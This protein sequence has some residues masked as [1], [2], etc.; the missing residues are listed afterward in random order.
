MVSLFM[1]KSTLY[2]SLSFL[3][4]LA[5]CNKYLDKEPDNRAQ[6][7]DTKKVSEILG[8][9]YPLGNYMGFNEAMSD[10]A[11][12][13]GEGGTHPTNHD[14]YYF[15]NVQNI[16]EDSPDFY[17]SACYS[18]I[19]AAN[20]ALEAC[21]KA[22]NPNDY[23]KQKGEALLAR[24]Y[25]HF[26]LV[27]LYAKPYDA[28]TS[29]SDPGIPYV[30]EP[31]TVVI[32]QYDRKTV[33]YVY[34]MIEKDLVAGLPLIDDAA[35]TVVRY[36][37]NRAAANAFAARFYLYK[38]D[39]QK[40]VQYATTAVPDFLPNLRK[41]NT[42]YQTYGL[43]NLPAQY[44]KTSEPANLLLVT[45]PTIYNYGNRY[46][47]YR[48]GLTPAKKDE[49]LQTPLQVT[50]GSWSF[51]DAYV[52]SQSNPA[53]PKFNYTD[54]AYLTPSS[55]IGTPYGTICLFTVEE[56]LFNKAEAN[57]YI[58]NYDA[59]IN[60]LNLYMSTRL[61]GVTPG[62]LP[63]NRQITQAKVL[64]HYNNVLPIKNALANFILELKRAEFIHEGMRWFDDLRYNITITHEFKGPGGTPAG[65]IKI[66]PT[67]KRRQL[68]L[69]D[70]VKLSGI[71]DLNR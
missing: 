33:A 48:Y 1:K 52:G 62:N 23:Q 60:D 16:E 30:T 71:T 2:T 67:D 21:N 31:E 17:W 51:I 43:N 36:H 63:S 24:A 44:Q 13:K 26:M 56:V 14:P 5:G 68:K 40:V 38:K 15:E 3:M 49:I 18:A 12:D 4:I 70:A 46:A 34:D 66:D 61:N 39:Y 57:A 29:A 28:A 8:T 22:A 54:F 65:S 41:W 59:A 50:G 35:Y 42:T 27:T 7:T 19:A 45:C 69:P 20:Q 55:N 6:L 37:F 25:A 11:D 47:T 9:A 32:K 58:G 10:N 64:A 53:I